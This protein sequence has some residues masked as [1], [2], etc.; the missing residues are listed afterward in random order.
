MKRTMKR[1]FGILL[2]TAFVLTA[3]G[4]APEAPAAEPAAQEEAK[5]EA[6]AQPEEPKEEAKPAE[7]EEPKE[8]E[9]TEEMGKMGMA[10]PWVK[11]TEEEAKEYCPRLFKAPEGANVHDWMKLE[12]SEENSGFEDPLVQLDFELDGLEFFARAQSGISDKEDISGMY[13]T[14]TDEEEATLA[15]WGEGRMPA[16][17]Y[18]SINDSGM[19]DLM[20][21]YDIEIGISYCL[22]VTSDD[23][24]GFDIQAVAEAMY[25]PANEPMADEPLNFL[26]EQAG[27]EEFKDFDDVISCLEAGQGYAMLKLGGN[28]K[29]TEVLAVS[30]LVF[31]ADQSSD[32]ASLYMLQ[33]GKPTYI[34]DV[35]GNG[36][37]FPLRIAD[38]IIYAGD[39]HNY[40]THFMA[41]AYPGIMVKDYVSDGIDYGDANYTGTLRE[42]NDFD[43]DQEFTGGEKE[44]E[45]LITERDKKPAIKFTVIK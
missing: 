12:G 2:L 21:W 32:R 14:W 33:D 16:K 40:M 6:P 37:A 4:K 9:E 41:S 18:R 17:F 29:E 26:T 39:N 44:F 43:H 28:D 13:L 38:G 23:L 24:D 36:S 27:R 7:A 30:D 1:I 5:E 42:A 25:D 19:A 34:G 31:E 15:N 11:I 10:N 3:C 35:N 8:A 20:T 22:G 45:Q